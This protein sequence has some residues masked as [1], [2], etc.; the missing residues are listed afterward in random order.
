MS[1]MWSQKVK[2][3]HEK[4]KM[5]EFWWKRTDVGT[6]KSKKYSKMQKEDDFQWKRTNVN[7]K[8]QKTV[9]KCGK[10]MNFDKNAPVWVQQVKRR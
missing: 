2:Q 7:A 9:K 5:N 10:R 3:N 8:S 1:K 4:R 6:K